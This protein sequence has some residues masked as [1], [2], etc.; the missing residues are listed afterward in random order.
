M[1]ELINKWIKQMMELTNKWIKQM[2]ELANKWSEY[3]S[4]RTNETY[5]IE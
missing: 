3:K 2:I 1:M 4:F 5:D